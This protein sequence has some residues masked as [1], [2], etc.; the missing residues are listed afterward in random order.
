MVAYE[1]SEKYIFISYAHKDSN[2]VISIIDNLQKKGFRLWYD[3]GIEAGTEWPAF[4]EDHLNASEVVIAFISQAAIESVN[5]RNEINYALSKK[6]EVLVIYLEDVEL[7]Y[8]LGLQLNS[9]Q[10]MYKNRHSSM[11]TFMEQLER[12]KILQNCRTGTLEGTPQPFENRNM[13]SF[14]SGNAVYGR[15]DSDTLFSASVADIYRLKEIHKNGPSLISRI[16]VKG[17]KTLSD[18]WPNTPYA[19]VIDIDEYVAVRFHCQLVK[20]ITEN[21]KKSIGMQIYDSKDALVYE[22][23]SD[24]DFAAG[25][26]RFSLGWVIRPQDGIPALPGKYTVLIWMENS[27]V[28]EYTFLLSSL[29]QYN[30]DTQNDFS[31][32]PRVDRT[33]LQKEKEAIEKKLTYPKLARIGSLLILMFWLAIAFISA[34]VPV[35]AVIFGVLMLI[36][37]FRFFKYTKKYIVQNGFLVLLLVTIGCTY[38]T[39]FLIVMTIVNTKDKKENKKRLKELEQI[40]L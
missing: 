8:G 38:Y 14:P 34:D 4:I 23:I 28:V 13:S 27:K 20:A 3:L 36:F 7:K 33:A 5:C 29:L 25:N 22:D 17:S 11:V 19:Q 2:V 35:L 18:C 40:G 9:V 39:L 32:I 30:P 12:S 37:F 1:G 26:D 10:S 31:E 24:L 6:K 15:D 21:S 16:A